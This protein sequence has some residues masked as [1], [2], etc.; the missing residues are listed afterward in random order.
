MYRCER[1][2]GEFAEFVTPGQCPLCGTW[3]K[4]KCSNC[5]HV[6]P[7]SVFIANANRCPRCNAVVVMA[8][9]R[10]TPTPRFNAKDFLAGAGCLLLITSCWLPSTLAAEI[11]LGRYDLVLIEV[12]M[13]A[14]GVI[15]LRFGLR[16]RATK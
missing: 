4:V 10:S 2:H 5:G 6:D 3:A 15:A 14:G 12:A 7:A 8:V 16:G 11:R 1:C 13:V 9:P